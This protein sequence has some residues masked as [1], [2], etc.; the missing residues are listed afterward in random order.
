MSNGDGGDRHAEPSRAGDDG[1]T[2]DWDALFNLEDLPNIPVSV[3]TIRQPQKHQQ[4]VSQ[5]GESPSGDMNASNDATGRTRSQQFW[6]S[7]GSTIGNIDNIP[8][9][10]FGHATVLD[11][12]FLFPVTDQADTFQSLEVPF[13]NSLI[14]DQMTMNFSMMSADDAALFKELDD[15]NFLSWLSISKEVAYDL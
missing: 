3:R 12:D 5:Q 4:Q 13:N 7:S 9:S 2:S 10:P 1:L 15:R 6:V 14:D 8:M 11:T